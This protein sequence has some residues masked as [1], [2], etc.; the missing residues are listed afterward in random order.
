M[1]LMKLYAKGGVIMAEEKKKSKVFSHS[2]ANCISVFSGKRIIMEEVSGIVLCTSERVVLRG[3]NTLAV[4]GKGLKL[5]E[6]GNDNVEVSGEIEVLRF[7]EVK[8]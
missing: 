4:E 6:L 3:K 8:P 7:R 2:K 5:V 1:V